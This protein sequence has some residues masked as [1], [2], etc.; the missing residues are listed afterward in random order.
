M[1]WTA[2]YPRFTAFG[3]SFAKGFG[4]QTVRGEV[5]YKPRFP[6][7]GSFGFH[8]ADLW[9]GVLGWDHDID[10]KYDLNLQLFGDVQEGSEASGSR[11]W[12]GATYEISGKWFRDALKTGVRG[13]LYTSGEGTL[14]EVFL[15]YE[16]DDH[17]KASTGVMFW[18][19]GEDTILGEYMDNDFVYLTLRYAF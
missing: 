18:T 9:Q 1:R 19:G 11:T 16:L 14:T 7:Q 3:T 15:E 5:A 17:W 4:S 8:R 6:V 12:H 10:S 13:K 2:E